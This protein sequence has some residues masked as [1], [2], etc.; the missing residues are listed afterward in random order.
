MLTVASVLGAIVI[1]S[2]GATETATVRLG[3]NFSDLVG[4][5]MQEFD[6]VAEVLRRLNLGMQFFVTDVDT[7][8][9]LVIIPPWKQHEVD[10][11]RFTHALVQSIEV[12]CWAIVQSDASTRVAASG[13]ADRITPVM[14][15]GIMANAARLAAAD[16]EWL[17]TLTTFPGG[18]ITCRNEEHC[19]LSLPD[20]KNPPDESL[21][22]EF[23]LAKDDE[24]FVR[25]TQM[26]QG[27]VDF[28]YG[29]RWRETGGGG[30]VIS[31]FPEL[32]EP[33]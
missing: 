7:C 27:R 9:A 30:E 8:Q 24:R 10:G 31:M 1:A 16:D 20:G 26:Y 6:S 29:V 14:I 22:F 32:P 11:L 28:I 25:V 17:K 23:I 13:P 18:V 12:E 33:I 5:R 15:H 19:L 3:Q 2:A 4:N 21:S